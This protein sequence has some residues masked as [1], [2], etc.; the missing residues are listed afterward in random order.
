MLLFNSIGYVPS[1][2]M[3]DLLELSTYQLITTGIILGLL[4]YSVCAEFN[5]Y[6]N[7]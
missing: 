6:M 3:L 4:T 5:K 2:N 1:K 7:L